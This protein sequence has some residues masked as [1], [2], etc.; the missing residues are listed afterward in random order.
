[1]AR[2]IKIAKRR[3]REREEDRREAATTVAV[4]LSDSE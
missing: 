1:M 2:D 3:E 4:E